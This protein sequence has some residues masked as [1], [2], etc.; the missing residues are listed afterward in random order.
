MELKRYRPHFNGDPLSY[1]DEWVDMRYSR[2]RYKEGGGTKEGYTDKAK[3]LW[4]KIVEAHEKRNAGDKSAKLAKSMVS[5][6]NQLGRRI[7]SIKRTGG[8]VKVSKSGHLMID[9]KPLGKRGGHK[10]GGKQK[11]KAGGTYTNYK[12]GGK[13]YRHWKRP[14]QNKESNRYRGDKKAQAHREDKSAKQKVRR[15]KKRTA[16]AASKSTGTGR[17]AGR[18]RK[19]A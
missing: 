12:Y 17:V 13:G 1:Q 16:K 18:K 7:A 10:A 9:G 5:M 4:A 15:A 8:N 6:E 11:L 2:K 19:K 3:K 14:V